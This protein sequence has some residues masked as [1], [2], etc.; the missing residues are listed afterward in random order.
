M[1]FL[2]KSIDYC[3]SYLLYI[4][5]GDNTVFKDGTRGF[6][7]TSMSMAAYIQPQPLLGEISG[8]TTRDCLMDRLNILVAR[9]QLYKTNIIFANQ[10]R[11]QNYPKDVIDPA[12][13]Q[14]FSH[15][16]DARIVYKLTD[17]ALKHFHTIRDGYIDSYNAI[18][19]TNTGIS[20]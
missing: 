1:Y 13:L 5:I 16:Q 12:F 20:T 18:Y 3:F 4:H 6:V 8:N 10:Q 15:H 2:I 19:D 17:E 9:P 14:M 7:A 11:I